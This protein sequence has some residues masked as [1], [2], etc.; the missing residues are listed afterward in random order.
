MDS[1]QTILLLWCD[2]ALLAVAKP[3]GLLTLPDGHNP[4]LPHI[5]MRLEPDYGRLWIVHRLDRQ[6]SGVLVLAR[7]AEAHRSLNAQFE[8]HA[9]QKVYH[10]IVQGLPAWQETAVALPLRTWVG[11]RKRT[12][13]DL[14]RG[15]QAF[16]ALQVLERGARHSL[17]E[18]RPTTGRT[19]QIRAHLAA[20]GHAVVGDN[21]YGP[22]AMSPIPASMGIER[23]MLHA[24]SLQ[25]THP[26][27]GELLSIEAP[28]PADFMAALQ[29]FNLRAGQSH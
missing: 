26:L 5:R 10:A 28:Y 24:C 2:P 1:L 14:E 17:V 8:S 18:A 7:S 6:T 4:T 12:A 23:T 25:L 3:P 22:Q 27:H 16:T 9:V 21:L 19:H 11:R 15:K 13:V 29:A 20:V